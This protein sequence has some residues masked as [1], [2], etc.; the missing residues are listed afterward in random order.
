MQDKRRVFVAAGF[1]VG[2]RTLEIGWS[3]RR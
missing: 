1:S 2:D 3:I